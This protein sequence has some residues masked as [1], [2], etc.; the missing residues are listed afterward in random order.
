MRCRPDRR[1]VIQ[2]AF[3]NLLGIVDEVFPI[4]RATVVRA[5]AIVLERPKLSARDATHIAVMT[6]QQVVKILTLDTG[7]DAVQ[8][9]ERLTA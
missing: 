8:G 1:D 3:D 9:I 4:D 6:R 2:P 7:F 5:R